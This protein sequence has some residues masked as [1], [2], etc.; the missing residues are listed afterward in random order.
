[1]SQPE[2]AFLDTSCVVRYLTG[3][4][5]AMAARARE[6]IDGGGPLILSELALVE[7]AHVLASFYEIPRG[8]LVEALTALIQRRNIHLLNLSKPLALEALR[9]CRP[10]KRVSFT[11]ALLWSEARQRGARRIYSFDR[12]FP[13]E[14]LEIVGLE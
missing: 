9:L 7:T 14:G 6:I 13:A 3:D 4:P 2:A 11:D 10:S 8:A 1:M 5:P 12:R